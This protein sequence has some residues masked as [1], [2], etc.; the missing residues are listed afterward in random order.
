MWIAG[1]YKQMSIEVMS[2]AKTPMLSHKSQD[3]TTFTFNSKFSC[4]R[5]GTFL[6]SWMELDLLLD[7]TQ[8]L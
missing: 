2:T 6:D 8:S 7:V 4:A 5:D 1:T 3:S